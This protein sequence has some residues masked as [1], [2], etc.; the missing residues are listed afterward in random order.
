MQYN[1][2][3]VQYGWCI[4]LSAVL[5]VLSSSAGHADIKSIICD[6]VTLINTDIGKGVAT[7]AIA[8]LGMGAAFGKISWGMA[9]ATCIGLAIM[10]NAGTLA[11]TL[12][13]TNHC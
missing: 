3:W 13:V 2:K 1:A 5:V 10:F 6:V 9:V 8:G 11:G 4:F 7:L 12:G